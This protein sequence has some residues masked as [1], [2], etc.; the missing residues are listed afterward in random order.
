[1]RILFDHGTPAPL[2]K[3]LG[4]HTVETAWERGWSTLSN[5]QLLAAAEAE[6]FDILVTTD[7]NLRHQQTLS[8]RRIAILVL[9][10]TSWP[11]IR[12]ATSLVLDGIE[13]VR[14]VHYLE[15]EIP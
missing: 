1:M 7:T 10:T 2:R 15:V 5:G 14:E 4:S 12:S 6:G 8:G 13:R 11:R 3:A 9:K